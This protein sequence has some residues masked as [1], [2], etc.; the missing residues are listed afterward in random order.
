MNEQGH[1]T[2]E[3]GTLDDA[4]AQARQ[5]QFD[6]VIADA[7]P[8]G[9]NGQAVK[10]VLQQVIAPSVPFIFLS[11]ADVDAELLGQLAQEEYLF[12]KPPDLPELNR[13]VGALLGAMQREEGQFGD[14][15]AFDRLLDAIA[16]Q[17]DSGVLTAYQGHLVKKIVFDAGRITYCGSNDPRDFIGQ[18]LIKAGL[19]DEADLTEAMGTHAGSNSSLGEVLQALGKVTPDQLNKTVRRKFI[20][21]VLSLYLWETGKW[22]Y[23]SGGVTAT[24][25]PHP[26]HIDVEPLRIEGRRRAARWKELRI[27]LPTDDIVFQVH[28]EKFPAGF[29][30]NAGD[31]R[32]IKLAG[33]GR[34]LGA[35]QLE[36]RG[37]EFAIVSRY[38]EFLKHGVISIAKGG[39]AAAAPG[40]KRPKPVTR[41]IRIAEAAA[42]AGDLP[43]AKAAFTEVLD[44]EPT[45]NFARQGLER[46]EAQLA[47]EARA[48]GLSPTTRVRLLVP[49]KDLALQTIEPSEAFILSRLAAGS[50]EVKELFAVSPLSE[51]QVLE[52]LQTLIG[53]KYVGLG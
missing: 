51:P 27:V 35:I 26:L 30:K 43:R 47:D 37:Q 3:A 50:V 52:V 44:D 45:N 19:I 49:V 18:A 24:D 36:L 16:K 10:P 9:A 1:V 53:K 5:Q 42:A 40:P 28:P 2:V 13:T 15:V 38:A 22:V 17:E 14:L 32:L 25:A 12:L 21:T 23:V 20:E 4:V 46:V 8:P 41:L 6:L 39:K 31:K 11:A 7:R 29:P 33:S 48:Q 34:S